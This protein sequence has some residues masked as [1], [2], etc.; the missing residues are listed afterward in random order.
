MTRELWL[1]SS[2]PL[3]QRLHQRWPRN[4]YRFPFGPEERQK[5]PSG[6]GDEMSNEHGFRGQDGDAAGNTKEFSTQE[7]SQ[8]TSSITSVVNP[9]PWI[10][11]VQPESKPS[12]LREYGSKEDAMGS[13]YDR[14]GDVW[15]IDREQKR[16]M[17]QEIRSNIDKIQQQGFFSKF[18]TGDRVLY[19]SGMEVFE[20]RVVAALP[21][22]RYRIQVQKKD[23]ELVEVT[24][25]M[26]Y[27]YEDL[28]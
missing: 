16:I 26:L 13:K 5:D 9:R 7:H 27:E 1:V 28:F 21:E 18:A 12:T 11:Y 4:P 8:G 22:E 17:R 24:G 2:N 14:A 23:G 3:V 15:R 20:A 25:S 19:D 10:P 6:D